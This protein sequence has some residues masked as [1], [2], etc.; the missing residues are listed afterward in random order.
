MLVK[1]NTR[2]HVKVIA[3]GVPT[4]HTY[5]L[6]GKRRFVLSVDVKTP[7]ETGWVRHLVD[8]S[9]DEALMVASAF[10]LEPAP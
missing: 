6:D 8:L 3:E 5:W 9:E 2:R 1:R 7:G 10:V 4:P